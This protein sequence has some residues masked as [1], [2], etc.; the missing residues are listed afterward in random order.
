MLQITEANDTVPRN[1]TS[2]KYI[3]GIH[4]RHGAVTTNSARLIRT[5]EVRKTNVISSRAN[6]QHMHHYNGLQVSRHLRHQREGF[7]ATADPGLSVD[8]TQRERFKPLVYSIR[9]VAPIGLQRH[10]KTGFTQKQS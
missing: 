2:D 6:I 9:G 10:G 1:F 7:S 4:G 5:T 8:T 3:F